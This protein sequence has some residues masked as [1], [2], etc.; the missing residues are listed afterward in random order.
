MANI[1]VVRNSAGPTTDDTNLINFLTGRSHSVTNVAD[2]SALPDSGYDICIVT[3]SGSSG[4]TAIGSIPT[5]QLPVM[6]FE[7]TW[8]TARM[9]SAAATTGGT[10]GTTWDLTTHALNSGYS[11]PMTVFNSSQSMYGTTNTN[12][13]SGVEV[14]A[15]ANGSTTHATAVIADTGATLTSGTA[16]NRRACM[17]LITSRL[18]GMVQNAPDWFEDIVL[19]TANAGAG[20]FTETLT[21]NMGLTD[22]VTTSTPGTVSP[23]DANG[24]TD[25][26]DISFGRGTSISDTL[27]ITDGGWFTTR[28]GART[29]N[30]GLTDIV[31]VVR[32]GGSDV[33]Q[34]D[35]L[36]LTDS[37]VTDAVYVRDLT[38]DNALTDS[39]TL[40]ETHARDLTD[41]LGLTDSIA[42]AFSGGIAL[43]ETLALTDVV[44]LEAAYVRDFTDT[45]GLGDAGVAE[46]VSLV[47][48]DSMG[49]SDSVLVDHQIGQIDHTRDLT[50]DLGLTD[51]VAIAATGALTLT[52]SADLT[53]SLLI[54]AVYDRAFADDMGLTD[55]ASTSLSGA[56]VIT[57]DMGLSDSITVV[58]SIDRTLFDY[59]DLADTSTAAVEFLRALIETLDIID[60]WSY[61]FDHWV[62]LVDTLGLADILSIEHVVTLA[63]DMGLV[64]SQDIQ[65]AESAYERAF[66]EALGLTDSILL[67]VEYVRDV[68]DSA[69]LSD[70]TGT[71]QGRGA[72]ATDPLGLT[73]SVEVSRA[74][75]RTFSEVIDVID[76]WQ[77]SQPAKGLADDANLSD[78]VGVGIGQVRADNMDLTDSI[79]VV[80]SAVRDVTDSMDLTDTP[81]VETLLTVVLTED[82]GLVDVFSR[83]AT[84]TR[85][86]TEDTGL[87]DTREVN[88][89]G[90]GLLY[91]ALALTDIIV[92]DM[93]PQWHDATDPRGV[94]G[95]DLTGTELVEAMRDAALVGQANAS[96]GNG[97][98][99]TLDEYERTTTMR[100]DHS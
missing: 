4:S 7:T 87:V 77:V 44:A 3:D 59:V 55:L 16:P 78:Q 58:L 94:V 14:L 32:A 75:D 9:S 17:G 11:D 88:L 95:P 21:D 89:S 80:L 56:G 22:T 54:V 81:L 10:S 69:A 27:G 57:E 70:T 30:V 20:Q 19:W 83:V 99:T 2:T 72:S 82:A 48:L 35:D 31:D 65:A 64:D 96:M 71:V 52:D 91:D 1:L 76:S 25:S 90:M 50:D 15:W 66:P 5:C 74:L 12:L 84:Y 36:G 23:L 98:A 40:E 26:L 73:D 45:V 100:G 38:D 41:D 92:V 67:A 51:Q 49:M 8:Q 6:L 29:D 97:R 33:Q 93:H 42:I 37:L 18:T 46:D 39:W 62:D 68:S 47:G 53:D 79:S 63:D 61:Y 34:A 60:S 13:P 85:V 28:V 86:F 24:L 43:E